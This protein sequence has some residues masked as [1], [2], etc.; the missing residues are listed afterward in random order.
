MDYFDRYIEAR[1]AGELPPDIISVNPLFKINWCGVD[2][3]LSHGTSVAEIIHDKGNVFFHFGRYI[4]VDD[5]GGS[6]LELT[7]FGKNLVG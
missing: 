7:E 5:R 6:P 1:D 4:S 2:I 3:P